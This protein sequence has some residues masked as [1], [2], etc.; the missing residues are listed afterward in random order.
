MPNEI[1]L[2]NGQLRTVLTPAEGA[3]TLSFDALHNGQWLPI[4]PDARQPDCDLGASDFLM[5]PY[6]NRIEN[7][8]FTFAGQTHQLAHGERH[9][10]HGDTRQ[11][12]WRVTESSSTRL[13]CIFESSDYQGVN[14]PW[15]FAAR[16]T[17]ELDGLTF[18]SEITLWN[19][20][21]TSMPAGFGWHPY[22]SRSLT[23]AG[24]PVWL[25]MRVTHVYPDA[26]GNRIPS[27]PAQ[28]LSTA[29]DFG[30]GKE[31]TPDLA[32]DACFYGYDGQ[33]RIAWPE[34]GVALSFDCSPEC[35]HLILYN[36][37]RPYFAAEPVTN[38]NNGVN[39]LAAGDE[40]SGVVVLAPGAELSAFMKLT[41]TLEG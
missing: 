41:V 26:N 38:A 30:A 34:S 35:S 6:S 10:I 36:P 32:L 37:A 7:G 21:E 1:T 22:F 40:T 12:A 19:R 33:G 29:Q 8:R 39:L 25:Q 16:V 14:W 20:G 27:G 13:V 5:L 9:S 31:L 11:R 2:N 15:P 3:G 24:E 4:M 17:Y 28:P 23:Q 18:A